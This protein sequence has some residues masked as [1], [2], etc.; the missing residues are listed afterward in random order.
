MDDRTDGSCWL[1]YAESPPRGDENC[2][3]E[4][5][6]LPPSCCCQFYRGQYVPVVCASSALACSFLELVLDA[7][8]RSVGCCQTHKTVLIRPVPAV[9]LNQTHTLTHASCLAWQFSQSSRGGSSGIACA[10]AL[11]MHR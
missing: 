6:G 10:L 9:I 7:V 8:Q 1:R 11:L 3:P 2:L 4:L 5:Q